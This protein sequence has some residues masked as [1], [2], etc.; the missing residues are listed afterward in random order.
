MTEDIR[1]YEMSPSQD[2]FKSASGSLEEGTL[3]LCLA[4]DDRSVI[5]VYFPVN[6]ECELS[7]SNAEDYSACWLNPCTGEK[8]SLQKCKSGVFRSPDGRDISD[9]WDNDWVLLLK[10][11]RRKHGD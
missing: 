4:N 5:V 6:G 7:L 8:T 10:N 1:F 3:P 9:E 11:G 2:L